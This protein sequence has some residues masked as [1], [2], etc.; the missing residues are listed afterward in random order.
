MISVSCS[1]DNEASHDNGS[2]TTEDQSFASDIQPIFNTYCTS[3]HNSSN[4][5]GGQNLTNYEG[6]MN[7]IDNGKLIGVITHASGYPA[8]PQGAAKLSDCNIS[9]ISAWITQGA[10][11]N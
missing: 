5:S 4:Q 2:C 6:V 11:N 1:K 10:L 8:M 7:A 9:K 3:C